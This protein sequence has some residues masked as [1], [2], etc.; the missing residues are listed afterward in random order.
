MVKTSVSHGP[1]AKNAA[2]SWLQDS[3]KTA[4]RWPK[5]APT[6]PPGRP[7]I[8][9]RWPKI[10]PKCA[11]IAPRWPKI[12]PRWP[13]DGPKMGPRG[14]EKGQDSHKSAKN[15]KALITAVAFF[16]EGPRETLVFS[17]KKKEKGK[18]GGREKRKKNK[19][20]C[21]KPPDGYMQSIVFVSE[22]YLGPSWGYLGRL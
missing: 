5:I 10:A 12:A 17:N 2:R 3:S 8:A 18:G 19:K 9:P 22:G 21:F 6:W 1:S 11:K 15:K 14:T 4:P 7:K 20:T 16:A 13:Q